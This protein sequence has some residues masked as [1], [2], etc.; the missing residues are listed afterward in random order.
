MDPHLADGVHK[1]RPGIHCRKA[2]HA[3]YLDGTDT[4]AGSCAPLDQCVR[5]LAA[6]TGASLPKALLAAT[7]NPALAL[8]G[9]VAK[10]K[11]QLKAGFHADLCVLDWQGNVRTTWVMGQEAW[12]DSRWGRTDAGNST[13]IA[14]QP[15]GRRARQVSG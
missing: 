10:T 15:C 14:A 9:E 4:L 3:V 5:N 11:G 2:G 7:L 8:G 6:F 13:N 12:R 1:W